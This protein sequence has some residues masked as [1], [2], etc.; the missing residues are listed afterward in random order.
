MLLVSRL[1]GCDKCTSLVGD[2]GHKGSYALVGR[3][4]VYE[5]SILF[6]FPVYL[7]LP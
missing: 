3:G 4:D 7:K 1:V 6:H 2:A 5:L